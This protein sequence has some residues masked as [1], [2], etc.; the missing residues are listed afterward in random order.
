M[1]ATLTNK[2]Y[3]ITSSLASA[4][5]CTSSLGCLVTA[6][7]VANVN[8]STAQTVKI[9]L[10]QSSV[11][12]SLVENL[13]IPVGSSI[14]VITDPVILKNGDSIYAQITTGT[15]LNVHMVMSLQLYY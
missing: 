9:T 11:D 13:T 4:Y 3:K 7:Q 1:A 2:P 6:I 8:A 15:T 14:S 5:D 10:R 12:Y